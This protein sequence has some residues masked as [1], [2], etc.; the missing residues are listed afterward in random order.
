MMVGAASAKLVAARKRRRLIPDLRSIFFM[1]LMTPDYAIKFENKMKPLR[2]IGVVGSGDNT[3]IEALKQ[4]RLA[5]VSGKDK[6]PRKDGA[7][8]WCNFF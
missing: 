8:R 4:E 6:L 3:F 1:K 2:A 7:A 5:A